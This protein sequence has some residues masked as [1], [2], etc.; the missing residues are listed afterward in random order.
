MK[1][2]LL[3]FDGCPYLNV[4]GIAGLA[5]SG[6]NY[7]AREAVVPLGYIPISLANQFKIDIVAKGEAPLEEVFG[8]ERSP[9]TRRMLQLRGTEEGRDVYGED[10]WIK[11]AEL[12][13]GYLV[14]HGIYNFVITD[15]RFDNEAE[16]VL[17]L[18]GIVAFIWGRGGAETEEAQAHASEQGLSPE[19][20]TVT[21]NN[22][23]E[24]EVKAISKLHKIVLNYSL[25]NT[26]FTQFEAPDERSLD[27]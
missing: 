13:I 27:L 3:N 16:W 2:K 25:E 23:P 20:V 1:G 18:G 14:E 21:I 8:Q 17:N 7:L 12:Q 22:S 10:V 26:S 24:N 9:E 15:V 11:A 19:Y 5:R 6:K 4:V